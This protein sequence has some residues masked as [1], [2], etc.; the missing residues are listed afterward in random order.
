MFTLCSWE[1]LQCLSPDR[2]IERFHSRDERPY[3]F[4]KRK[5][6]FCIKKGLIPGGMAWNTNM[7]AV[8]LFWNTNMAAV[9]SYENAL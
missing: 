4:T 2:C 9:T 3:W 5:D 7:A 1:V 6:N 8:S